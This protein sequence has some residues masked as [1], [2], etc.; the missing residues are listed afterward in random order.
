MKKILNMM[1]ALALLLVQIIP[2]TKVNA[3]SGTYANDGE[4]TVNGAVEGKTYSAYQILELESYDTEKGAYTYRLIQEEEGE[5]TN[6]WNIFFNQ[7]T[8]KGIY[9]NIDEQ[10]IVTWKD[11]ADVKEFAK[12]AL[13]YAKANNI[14]A[15]ATQV[16][17][18]TGTVVFDE[19]Y[20]GYY[21]IDSSL[22][23]IC[24]L[25]T[26]NPTTTINEKNSVPT[27]EKEVKENTNGD[28][29]NAFGETNTDYI[30][31]TIEF[32]TTINVGTDL[33]NNENNAG[34]QNYKLYDVMSNGLTLNENSI[35][36]TL[37]GNETPLVKGT[38]YTVE[39]NKKEIVNEVEKTYTFVIDFTDA[40][41]AT[42]NESDEIIVEYTALLNKNAVIGG[43]G[44]PNETWLTY[45]DNHETTHD[46]TI[47]YTYSFDLV[48]HDSTNTVL[49]GAKFRLYD[50]L[51][52]GNEIA[53]I[54]DE[55]LNAYR[56]TYEDE[57][58][59]EIEVGQAKIVGLDKGTFYLEET[60]APEGYNK[61]TSRV[62]VT[63]ENANLDAEVLENVYQSGGIHVLNTTGAELPE[64]GGI[65]TML[66]VTIGTLMV[67]GFGVLLVTKLRISK[68]EA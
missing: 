25:N 65:G 21:L 4:I 3:V 34:A 64:T 51:T 67:L 68:M 53:V 66:F 35:T 23:T 2:T 36:V 37:N 33:E 48:K 61:L 30:G 42:L 57:T 5:E 59:Q 56:T 45:G 63:I 7:E 50:A 24:G 8:I 10:E 31:K 54:W 28:A 44:N 43:N 39:F 1:F 41:E 38:D 29:D 19:L 6:P 26:T 12:L 13:A 62:T 11:D 14:S 9:V 46:T 32:Q 17:G 60:K 20:L 55:E 18:T 22:G 58:G 16:A 47:T 15:T 49:P 52:G 27:V 40:F